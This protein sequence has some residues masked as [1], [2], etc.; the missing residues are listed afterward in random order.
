MKKENISIYT[1]AEEANVSPSTVS[2][3]L[4]GNV[5]VSEEKRMRVQD[6]IDKYNFK[7]NVLAQEL[8][9]LKIKENGKEKS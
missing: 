6:L 8:G 9:R 4:S 2:R 7:P 3:V 1:I 5:K